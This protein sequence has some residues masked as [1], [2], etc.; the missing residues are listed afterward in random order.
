MTPPSSTGP[1]IGLLGRVKDVRNTVMH[2]NAPSLRAEQL[3]LLDS[4]VSMLRLY[5]PDYGATSRGWTT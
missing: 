1:I 4:S 5:D 2:F 3:D